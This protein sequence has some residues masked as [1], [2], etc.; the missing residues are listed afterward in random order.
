MNK[1]FAVAI[2]LVMTL[3][4]ATAAG[5]LTLEEARPAQVIYPIPTIPEEEDEIPTTTV[6]PTTTP[7]SDGEI[8]AATVAPTTT[9]TTPPSD[10]GEIPAATVAATTAP[11]SDDEIPA[12]TVTPTTIPTSDPF[13][14]DDGFTLDDLL[15]GPV[16]LILAAL[17]LLG[18]FWWWIIA[19]RRS[20]DEEEEDVDAAL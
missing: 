5:A 20:D 11:P 16:L 12:T 17:G 6:T 4:G 8:P 14:G 13:S 18:L 2:A 1:I 7:P 3:F 19:K 15:W 9:T 10:D